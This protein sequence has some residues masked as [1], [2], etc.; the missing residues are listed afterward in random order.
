MKL[1][2]T[3]E[4]REQKIDELRAEH[5]RLCSK[6]SKLLP[7]LDHIAVNQHKQTIDEVWKELRR[8][9]GALKRTKRS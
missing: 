4:Q 2:L 5:S 8:Q 6:L 1:T 9:E 3:R 7:T